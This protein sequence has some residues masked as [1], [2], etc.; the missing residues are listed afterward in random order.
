M[1]FLRRAWPVPALVVVAVLAVLLPSWGDGGPGPGEADVSMSG[2][3]VVHRRDGSSDRVDGRT[4]L[5]RGDTIEVTS[6]RATFELAGGVGLEGRAGSAGRHRRG[7]TVRMGAVP[8]LEAGRLLVTAEHRARI[9]SAGTTVSLAAVGDEPAALK[10]SR[11]VGLSVGVYRGRSSLDSAGER[12]N[13]GALRRMEVAAAGELPQAPSPLRYL[14]TD[15]W[16]RRF[17]GPA[18]ALDGQLRSLLAG[19]RAASTGAPGASVRYLRSVLPALE[20][21]AS[22]ARLVS[23]RRAPDDVLVGAA[24]ASLG[25]DGSFADRWR[26]VFSFHDDGATWGLVALDQA[27][28]TDDVV[29]TL[30]GALNGTDFSFESAAAPRS[31]TTTPA[32]APPGTPPASTTLPPTTAPAAPSTTAG[33]GGVVPSGP[34]SSGS[35]SPGG[36]APPPTAPP[37]TAPPRT[38]PPRTA[39]PRTAPPR[40]APPPT[41]P[42]PTA[43]PPTAPP[44]PTTRPAPPTTAPPVVTAPPVT[45]PP[46]TDPIAGL[47]EGAGEAVGTVV[48]GVTDVLGGLLAPPPPSG[49]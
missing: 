17:L 21:E 28:P 42:P 26:A 38:A 37:R 10:A 25:E 36:T 44:P 49:G 23:G 32:T 8:S 34:P 29:D 31:S 6:G 2:T 20:G 11:A 27:V 35:G 16:D 48:G 46:P 12:R 18:V 22:L 33:G 9:S 24:I 1:K 7:T 19:Y 5:R 13:L 45:A 39:P 4:T 15:G 41:A 43:P 3:A 14:A 30:V 47:V 40:T